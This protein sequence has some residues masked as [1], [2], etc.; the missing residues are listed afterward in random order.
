MVFLVLFLLCNG[1]NIPENEVEWTLCISTIDSLKTCSVMQL[2]F[3]MG[4]VPF[5]PFTSNE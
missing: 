3:I 4:L 2:V 1:W 5:F